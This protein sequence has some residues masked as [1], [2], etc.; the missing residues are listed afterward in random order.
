MTL[1]AHASLHQPR[2]GLYLTSISRFGYLLA[3]TLSL[4]G[5]QV[6]VYSEVAANDLAVREREAA[7]VEWQYHA[8]L[9]DEADLASVGETRRL[10][11]VDALLWELRSSSPCYPRRLRAWLAQADTVAA[12]NTIDYAGGPWRNVHAELAAAI[13]NAGSLALTDRVVVRSGRPYIRPTIW[14][15]RGCRQGYFVHPKFVREPTLRSEMFDQAWDAE[16]I[17]P[18]RLVFSGNPQPA[19]RME[20]VREIGRYLERRL[21]VEVLGHHSQMEVGP[22]RSSGEPKALWMVREPVQDPDW[23]HRSDVIPPVEW[24]AVMRRCDFAFCPPGFERKTHRVIESLLQGVVPILDCPEEYD[25]GLADGQNCIVAK[26]GQW[27]VA[28]KRALELSQSEIVA[29]RKA[30][31]QIAV[32]FLHYEGACAMWLDRMGLN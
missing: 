15:G 20:L 7:G 16:V 12:W 10:P 4:G 29:L 3:K 19:F 24:P 22:G 1:G 6:F 25:L 28:V 14:R 17:R 18:V 13:R 32:R 2:V 8:W 9:F 30:V 21:D 23:F 27:R 5:S 26:K 11:Q 31:G